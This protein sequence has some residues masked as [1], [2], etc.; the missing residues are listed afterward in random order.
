MIPVAERIIVALD[1]PDAPTAWQW[2]QRLP[3]VRFWKVG[4]E[5]FV[6]AGPG[7]V[8]DLKAQGL[9][10]FL[11]L[12][13]HDIPNTVA[14]ACR[15]VTH[16]GAD[17]L[18]VHAA[19]G[20]AMLRAAADACAREAE[21]LGI[22]APAVLAVTLLTSLDET[23]LK[24]ELLI[25]QSPT[26][27]VA[28]LAGLALAGGVPGIVCSPHEA[29][30][31]RARLGDKLLIVTPGIRPAGAEVADQRRTCTPLQAIR[32]GADYL[33]VGRPVLAAP[34]PAA[35]FAAIVEEIAL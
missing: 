12:K 29:E 2:V 16:L 27:Y 25:E 1:V 24:D 33:V 8:K 21:H 18:T 14:G 30:A 6:A 5:L 11:D 23:V 13:L 10:V 32:A 34:D 20:T 7:L 28:H 35:A 4:L 3:Q 26:D 9:R 31:V 17:L 19:G 15:R 22:P